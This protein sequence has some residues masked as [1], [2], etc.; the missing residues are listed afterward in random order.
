MLYYSMEW[1][2]IYLYSVCINQKRIDI[3]GQHGQSI[4]LLYRVEQGN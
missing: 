4:Q 3:F 2:N 1:N